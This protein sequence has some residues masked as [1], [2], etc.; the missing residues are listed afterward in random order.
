MANI[1]TLDEADAA[2]KYYPEMK[3]WHAVLVKSAHQ[4]FSWVRFDPGSIYPL[5]SHPFEQTSVVIDGRMRLTVGDEVR[6]VG[7]GDMWFVP[8]DVPH[9]GE[10][11]GDGPVTFI[12]VYSPPSAGDE[13]DITY[14]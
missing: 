11:L 12:D 13:R 3:V 9:G 2:A 10:V 1:V 6:E 4:E 7:P 8:P 5:H 14:Y